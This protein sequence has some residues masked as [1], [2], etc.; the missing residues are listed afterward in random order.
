MNYNKIEFPPQGKLTAFG[1][2]SVSEY[3]PLAACKFSYN[4]NSELYTTN[5]LND[6]TADLDGYFARLQ[7]GTNSDG[8]AS[9]RSK[10]RKTSELNEEKKE[11]KKKVES[12]SD[13]IR[14]KGLS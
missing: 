13:F 2:S 3:H 8:F 12:F 7:T 6:G 11:E 1:E 9:I 14:K 5:T 10:V 4:I